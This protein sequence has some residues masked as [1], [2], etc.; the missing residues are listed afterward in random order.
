MVYLFIANGTEEVEAMAP[1]DILR[2]G[3]VKV[4]TVGV[5]GKTVTGSHGVQITADIEENEVR[6]DDV[7]AVI[8]PGGMPGTTN[9]ED[10]IVV[11]HALEYAYKNNL[12]IGAI[13]AAPSI[14]GHNGFLNGKKATCFPGFE[15]E[16]VGAEYTGDFVTQDKNIVTGKGAGAA[17][18]FGKL[19]LENLTDEETA[20]KVYGSMQCPN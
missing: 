17:L 2:R 9:L 1:L 6:L 14:L 20:R 8:L 11:H 18:Q 12:L 5:G 13:C 16:L 4:T 7:E 10:S 19:L 3:G 15:K